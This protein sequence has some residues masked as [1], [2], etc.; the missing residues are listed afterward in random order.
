MLAEVMILEVPQGRWVYGQ[1]REC[2][3]NTGV[4]FVFGLHICQSAEILDQPLKHP[5][6]PSELID[7]LCWEG[8]WEQERL[9]LPSR[10]ELSSWVEN[11]FLNCTTLLL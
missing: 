7:M 4:A 3:G 10:R 5:S 11:P 9:K 1:K 8:A 2:W 6:E